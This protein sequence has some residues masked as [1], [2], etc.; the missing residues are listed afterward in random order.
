MCGSK[1]EKLRQ[2]GEMLV[3]QKFNVANICL[4]AMLTV[5][6][7]VCGCGGDGMVSVSGTVTIDGVPVD[8]GSIKLV[9]SDSPVAGAEIVNGKF[10]TRTTTGQKDVMIIAQKVVGE[11]E[12]TDPISGAK[13]MTKQYAPIIETTD[14]LYGEIKINQKMDVQKSGNN[15]T[16]DIKSED[17]RKK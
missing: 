3:F 4:A 9:A 5:L 13:V 2:E 15:F 12:E 14:S 11:V 16:F 1:L 8:N 6:L 10:T 7:A 17:Y